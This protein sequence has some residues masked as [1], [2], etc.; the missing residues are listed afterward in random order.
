M[1][2]ILVIENDESVR[3]NIIKLLHFERLQVIESENGQIGVQMAKEQIP[4]LILCATVMPNM[5]GYDVKNSLNR[6]LATATIPF[7]FLGDKFEK[8]DVRLAMVLGADDYLSKPFT[9]DELLEAIF[10]RLDKQALIDIST[11]ERLD[12]LCSNITESLPYELLVPL[13]QIKEFLR[14][15]TNEYALLNQTEIVEIAKKS[16]AASL[17][18]QKL[19]QNFLFYALLEITNNNPLQIEALRSKCVSMSTSV[20]TS[21][22]IEKA[23]YLE[24]EADLHLHLQDAPVLILEANFAKIVEELVDN[25]FK[26]SSTGMPVHLESLIRDDMFVL[27][28]TNQG[29]GI[30]ADQIAKIGAY[31]Q[32]ERK[33]RQEGVG[34]GLAIVTSIC[35][36]Y[37]GKFTIDSVPGEKTTVRV[38]LPIAPQ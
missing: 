32:F 35:E 1:H 2:K 33:S 26:F 21:V 5:N 12:E 29:Q 34:L 19:N 17:H 10:A 24:R 9:N 20:V 23:K 3:S 4:N 15:L 8:N 28:I 16:Y 37:A 30:T 13:K 11:K 25:A 31:M 18:L 7:I 27:C 14:A 36:L 22:A 38:A 6:N